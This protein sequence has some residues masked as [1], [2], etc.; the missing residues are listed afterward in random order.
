MDGSEETRRELERYLNAAAQNNADWFRR[1]PNAP[2]CVACA[3]KDGKIGYVGPQDCG[4]SCQRIQSAEQVVAEGRATCGPLAA[5]DAGGA[6]AEGKDAHVRVIHEED[7]AGNP[8]P[9][10]YHAVVGTKGEDG[11]VRYHDPSEDAV[12]VTGR[13]QCKVS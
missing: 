12:Q 4:P 5:Y 11:E 13:C 10:R 9:Y 3:A 8:V 7:Q 2:C 6:L 1:H